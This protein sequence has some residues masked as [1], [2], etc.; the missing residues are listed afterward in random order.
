MDCSSGQAR[1]I[2]FGTKLGAQV[3]AW[4]QGDGHS[5]ERTARQAVDPAVS[6]ASSF[7]RPSLRPSR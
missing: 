5:A 7:S 6:M 3:M 4:T 1:M 2:V